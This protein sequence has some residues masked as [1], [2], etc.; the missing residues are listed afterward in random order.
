VGPGDPVSAPA[1][2]IPVI[3]AHS[4]SA[5]LPATVTHYSRN[6]GAVQPALLLTNNNPDYPASARDEGISGSVELRFRISTTGDVHDIVVVKGPQVLAQAAVNAVRE[7][8]Y[9]PARV[10][11]V[12]T[13]TEASAIFDFKLN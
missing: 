6:G 5:T 12:P 1:E 8:R 3:P 2:F 9:K 7:R 4:A 10:D 13:E 11:G